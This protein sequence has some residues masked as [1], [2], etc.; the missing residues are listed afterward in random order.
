MKRSVLFVGMMWLA[1]CGNAVELPEVCAVSAKG[2]FLTAET[3]KASETEI[4][5]SRE[6]IADFYADFDEQIFRQD[7]R[8]ATKTFT[9][10][11][12]EEWEAYADG[13]LERSSIVYF[14]RLR[15]KRFDETTA[16][17]RSMCFMVDDE[18]ACN[19]LDE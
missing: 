4:T 11:P 1:G 14:T 17:Y 2:N 15:I 18:C 8:N 5:A 6:A 10:Y 12:R 3:L 9:E 13:L 16:S 19:H 7:K